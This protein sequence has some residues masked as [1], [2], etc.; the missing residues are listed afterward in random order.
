M[1]SP[2]GV[3]GALAGKIIVDFGEERRKE[4]KACGV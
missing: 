1:G 2:L 3:E 4:K